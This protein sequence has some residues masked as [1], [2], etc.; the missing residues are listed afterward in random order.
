MTL[1]RS[2]ASGMR[3]FLESTAD[4]MVTFGRDELDSVLVE[5]LGLPF[6]TYTTPLAYMLAAYKRVGEV[7]L[8]VRQVC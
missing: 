2:R 8:A 4:D 7:N 1:D 3:T 5:R 6:T